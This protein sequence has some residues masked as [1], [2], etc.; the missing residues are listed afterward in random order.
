MDVVD[1][2][3]GPGATGVLVETHGPERCHFVLRVGVGLGQV[4]QFFLGNTRNLVR[5]FKCVLGHKRLELVEIYG[6]CVHW[7]AT[8]LS[9]CARVAIVHRG[10]FQ[11]MVRAQAISNVGH[12]FSEVD[13]LL[14]E[15]FVHGTTLN[16][17]VADVVHDR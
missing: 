16:D 4:Q 17:V 8:W 15:V 10:L 14:D 3:V 9:I 13:V 6:L 12:A 2:V 1:H 5:P 7:I 11:R